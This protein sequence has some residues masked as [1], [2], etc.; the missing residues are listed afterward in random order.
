MK[1]LNIQILEISK[2]IGDLSEDIF[3]P[4]KF[5]ESLEHN[6]NQLGKVIDEYNKG[7]ESILTKY[8]LTKETFDINNVPQ[9][10]SDD[11]KLELDSYLSK[12]IEVDIRKFNID[13]LN[14]DIS[15]K[16]YN[17]IKFMIERSL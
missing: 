17:I 6:K 4:I 1:L 2:N 11:F 14:L 5:W 10:K 3:M 13:K 7:I 8:G 9:D 15:G 12:E 16:Q